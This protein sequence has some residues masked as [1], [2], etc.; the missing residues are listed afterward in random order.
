MTMRKTR[1]LVLLVGVL[2]PYVARLPG[3][4]EWF[5]PYANAGI[6]GALLLG[7]FNAIAWGAILLASHFYRRPSSLLIPSILGFGFLAYAHY[8]LDLAADAQAAIAIVFIPIYA[9]VPIGA[10]SIIGYLVDRAARRNDAP[11]K[12]F[13]P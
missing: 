11:D 9:L 5:L 10:G 13:K 3:G 4:L 7:G 12:S 6:A 1:W 2:L 8:S